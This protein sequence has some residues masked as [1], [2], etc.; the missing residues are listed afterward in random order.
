M[1]IAVADTGSVLGA[2]RRL[3]LTRSSIR[4]RLAALEAEVGVPLLERDGKGTRLTPAGALVVQE[5]RALVASSD[6]LKTRA[7]QVA[8]SAIGELRVIEPVG[9]PAAARAQALLATRAA[10]AGLKIIVIQVPDPLACVDEPFDLML[11]GGDPP[12]RAGWFSRVVLRHPLRVLA[13][14]D[15]LSAHGTPTTLDEL[16][17]HQLLGWS[18]GGRSATRW[19]LVAGG[20]LEVE[21]WIESPDFSLLRHLAQAGGGLLLGPVLTVPMDGP[22]LVPVLTELIGGERVFRITSRLSERADARTSAVIGRMLEAIE[23]LGDQV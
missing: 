18:P 23:T 8:N 17:D 10:F 1:L 7:R 9:M 21:P 11:H 2:T 19:P 6:D 3:G 20:E 4:R 16:A 14:E 13:S 5:G 15:Y 12:E 22:P